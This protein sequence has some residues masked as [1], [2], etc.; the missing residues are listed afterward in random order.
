MF[1]EADT[2][3]IAEIEREEVARWSP[4]LESA[5]GRP[6][7]VRVDW[8]STYTLSPKREPDFGAAGRQMVEAFR[9]ACEDARTRSRLAAH[10]TE[11]EFRS[12]AP[13]IGFAAADLE[14]LAG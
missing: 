5:I 1:T 11:V 7:P 2:D 14:L 8:E 12:V 13:H 6:V 3:R 4:A 10:A 9:V